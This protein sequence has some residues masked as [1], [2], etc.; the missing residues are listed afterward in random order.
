MIS[1]WRHSGQQSCTA[2][3]KKRASQVIYSAATAD[4]L[5]WLDSHMHGWDAKMYWR[6]FE[7]AASDSQASAPVLNWCKSRGVPWPRAL[8]VAY[9]DDDYR[10]LY[11][12]QALQWCT[13]HGSS[14]GAWSALYCQ[15]ALWLAVG[16]LGAIY[17]RPPRRYGAASLPMGTSTAAPAVAC[18]RLCGCN[19]CS[20]IVVGG[21][22]YL[23]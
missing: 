16:D 13:E 6:I 8:R 21:D 2:K 10:A 15:S 19:S 9:G 11:T 4:T 1:C 5:A 17:A 7:A 20:P 3:A 22:L 23:T 12:P 14:W 18:N